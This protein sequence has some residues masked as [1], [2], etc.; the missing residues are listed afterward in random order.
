MSLNSIDKST[1]DIL[2]LPLTGW[3][4]DGVNTIGILHDDKND[5]FYIVTYPLPIVQP[6][7]DYA[8]Y[9]IFLL[10]NRFGSRDDDIFELNINNKRKGVIFP[11]KNYLDQSNLPLP[12]EDAFL[13]RFLYIAFYHLLEAIRVK[14]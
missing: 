2:P 11:L 9:Q 6:S 13:Y 5:N 8:N 1:G 4:N 14:K 3:T 10:K 7:E 12:T